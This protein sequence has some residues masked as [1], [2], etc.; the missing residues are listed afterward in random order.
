MP[1]VKKRTKSKKPSTVAS[2]HRARILEEALNPSHRIAM[3][4]E[5]KRNI[6]IVGGGIIGSTTA[7]F[8]TRHPKYNPSLHRITILEATAIAAGA[9]GKAGGLLALWAYPPCLV[10]LSYRLHRELA[11]EHGGAERWGYRRV[12]CGSFEARVTKDKIEKLRQAA[13]KPEAVAPGANNGGQEK[14]W[15]KLPKQDEAAEAMLEDSDLPRDLDWVDRDAIQSYAEMGSPGATETAQ[16]HPFHFTTSI[17]ALAQE[18][19][20]EILLGAQ[21]KKVNSSD[22]GVRSVEY[23]DRESGETR[24]I[25][26]VTDLLVSAGPWTGRL[27]PAS[28]VT[29]LRAHSV[30]YN[31]DVSP[32]AVFTS[33]E[34]PPD[35]VPEHRATKGQRRRHKRMVDPEIYA[36]P[37]GEVYACGEPDKNIPLP[38]T[39]DKVQVD[40]ANC[41]DIISYIATVSPAL[42]A[43][44]IKARQACYL[45]QVDYGPLIGPTS[46]PGLW[47]ASGHTCWGIQNGPA[48]GKLM[49][50]YI[51]DGEAT[52]SDISSLDPRK[53]K[54]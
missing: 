38:E 3:D 50:E 18:K 32:Y 5:A 15:E 47:L 27:V 10:P 52:S 22:A 39:A 35:F 40:E 12:G 28:K 31:A 19:G 14:G 2:P 21:L 45:P 23:L 53:Y 17:A 34:L 7:Y 49:S 48:T 42:A 33:I 8:L 9:S 36:R 26:D 6:V 54:C 4:P 46:V 43:A 51:L 25:D 1:A 20:V 37:G 11:A 16:V 29:G 24:T 30:V 41:D 44:P 13:L